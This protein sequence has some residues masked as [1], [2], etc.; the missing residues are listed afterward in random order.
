MAVTGWILYTASDIAFDIAD[1]GPRV[2]LS[3]GQLYR[4]E[5]PENDELL[6]WDRAWSEQP[7]RV[8]TALG[9]LAAPP[10][11]AEDTSKCDRGAVVE[12]WTLSVDGSERAWIYETTDGDSEVTV[13]TN[14]ESPRVGGFDTLPDR[15]ESGADARAAAE[16]EADMSRSWRADLESAGTGHDVYQALAFET[17]GAR[18]ASEKLNELGIKGLRYLD[19]GS[20]GQGEGTRNFVIFDED[21]IEVRE[22]FY[23][24]PPGGGRKAIST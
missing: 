19:Q 15:Y 2:E 18:A 11:W 1:N 7:E 9:G 14:R 24:G 12:R 13:L 20:P 22:T 8:K 10:R 16:A 21:A 6:D 17:G 4:V 23:Q 3:G 5:V